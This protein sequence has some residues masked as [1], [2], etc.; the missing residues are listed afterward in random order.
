MNHYMST[1]NS[2]QE[3]LTDPRW[4]A[5]MNE[6]MASLQKN[7]TWE[8]VDRPTGKKPIGC[9]WIF[10]MKYK[11][12]GM[13]KRFKARLVTKKYAQTYG[14]DYTET[15]APVAKINTV[16]V[17]LSLAANFDWPLQ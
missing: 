15:F 8:L 13:I 6:E 16:W 14:I 12:D 1:P 9:R 17:L 4:K 11:V 2:V 10:T 3:A 7:Q 5:A